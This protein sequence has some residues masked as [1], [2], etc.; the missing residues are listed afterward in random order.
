M[1][2]RY[3]MFLVLFYWV[4][5]VILLLVVAIY[6]MIM[7]G[8]LSDFLKT[9]QQF[10][11]NIGWII[12]ISFVAIIII[13]LLGSVFESLDASVHCFIS[14]IPILLIALLSYSM[15]RKAKACN[16]NLL[17]SVGIEKHIQSYSSDLGSIKIFS[18][19]SLVPS[20][21]LVAIFWFFGIQLY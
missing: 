2:H 16:E 21:I 15:L 9:E 1:S 5:E 20:T 18:W 12:G 6:A 7:K 13:L 19:V 3:E 11:A 14:S 17:N 10:K 8:C 4:V